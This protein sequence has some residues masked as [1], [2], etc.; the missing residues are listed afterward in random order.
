MN[1]CQ[2]HQT[3]I[4]QLLNLFDFIILLSNAHIFYN[5]RLYKECNTQQ[6]KKLRNPSTGGERAKEF[7]II[8]NYLF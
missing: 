2:I 3:L 7:Q 1:F 8:R 4:I 6:D 5:E